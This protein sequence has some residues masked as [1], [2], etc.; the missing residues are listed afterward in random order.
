MS[1]KNEQQL[2]IPPGEMTS[3]MR[4][5]MDPTNRGLRLINPQGKDFEDH[6]DAIS[7][8]PR[9][10]YAAMRAHQEMSAQVLAVGGTQKMAAK[11]AG[12]SP[13][14]IKK[15]L[16]DA[17]FRTRVEELR[18]LLASRIKGKILR[19]LNRRTTGDHLKNMD[20]LDLLRVF[21][22]VTVGG[23]GMNSVVVEGD[24]NVNQNRYEAILAALFNP[25]ASPESVDFPG[26]GPEDLSLSS[27]DPQQ[28][29]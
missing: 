24:L 29:G 1:S 15:Y 8:M 13:R 3:Q 27:G 18:G 11:Y 17:D 20:L 23:K 16:T 2:I 9:L 5:R 26:Y 22:R 28:P 4:N 21:D 7:K 12:V 19:E 14:Q 6:K 10:R 25:N